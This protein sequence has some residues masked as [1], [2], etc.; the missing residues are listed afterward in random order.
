MFTAK[1]R[2]QRRVLGVCCIGDPAAG[3]ILSGAKNLVSVPTRVILSGAKNLVSVPT[4]RDSALRS[5]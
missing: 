4:R 5:E 1:Q 2:R 3:V